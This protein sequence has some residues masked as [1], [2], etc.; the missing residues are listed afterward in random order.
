[1]K[2]I[3]GIT[4]LF[5]LIPVIALFIGGGLSCKSAEFGPSCAPRQN[6]MEMV[7]L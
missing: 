5:R 2:P 3:G 6:N 7:S 4:R 1:M